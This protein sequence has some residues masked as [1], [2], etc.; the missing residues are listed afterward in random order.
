M[1][2]ILWYNLQII[3]CELNE[4]FKDLI[5]QNYTFPQKNFNLNQEHN[6]LFNGVDLKALIDEHGSPLKITYLPKVGEQ[7][8]AARDY[9]QQ[10]MQAHQYDQPYVY[11]YCTKSSHFMHIVD[12]VLK[13]Q[14]HLELSSAFDTEIV[15]SL[16]AQN[17]LRKDMYILCNGY[18]TPSYLS[19]IE[20]IMRAG[21]TNVIPILD[22]TAELRAYERFR[23]EHI[24][25]GMRMAMEEG[26]SFDMYNSRFGIRMSELMDFYMTRIHN[27]G[28]ISLKMLHFFVYSGIKDKPY[29]W[30]ELSAY[31]QKYAELKHVCPTLDAINMGGG[32]PIQ[33]SL[34]FKYDYQD[35]CN[36]MVGKIKEICEESGVN[37]PAIFSEFGTFTV[38]ET[39]AT[40]FKIMGTKRQNDRE[41]WYMVDNSLITTLPDM[42]ADKQKF[43][44]LPINKWDEEYQ[45]VILGGLTC[46]NDDFCNVICDN[47]ELCLPIVEPHND[48]HDGEEPLYVGFFHT[49]AYQESLG[50]F[51]G[52]NH[53]LIPTPK[54]ILI[55]KDA[56]DKFT[57]KVL[58]QEQGPDRVLE[59]LG[60]KNAA[61]AS[62]TSDN[63]NYESA[64]SAI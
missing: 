19:G 4:T 41:T 42:W 6:L 5:A 43:I 9:F 62:A 21:F 61:N 51:G 15:M 33:N 38:G 2:G 12:Q 29:Y 30:K 46:D 55:D 53:C 60:Y 44:L 10:A 56:Q 1:D 36:R 16:H 63:T 32:M 64:L 26:E 50:G 45:R 40:L 17:R 58:A 47:E 3:L 20:K 34:D 13:N 8:N 31:I 18:K 48:E 37:T 27:H 23:V 59:I 11:T 28:K 22:S 35:M 39:S 25:I 14:A 54:H 24:Q 7:I 57:Y 49:G 52:I